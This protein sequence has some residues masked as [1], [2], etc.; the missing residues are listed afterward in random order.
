MGY[1][2]TTNSVTRVHEGSR[3]SATEAGKPH[4]RMG[5][6]A[7]LR[8]WLLAVL[9]V[10]A[11]L[12]LFHLGWP[13]LGV[14]E[15]RFGISALNILSD[16]HQL[17]IV[18]EDPLGGVGT[19]PYLYPL[20]L[21][22]SIALLG[23]TEFAVRLVNVLVLALGGLFVYW[24][25]RSATRKDGLALLTF[26]SFLLNP[27]TITYARSA[28][29][30]PLVV[31]A[32]CLALL[33]AEKWRLTFSLRWAVVCGSALGFGYMAK[34]WLVAP[35]GGAAFIV[36]LGPLFRHKEVKTVLASLAALLFSFL[37]AA[38]THLLLVA[39]LAPD[40]IRNWL[41]L[42]FLFSL[43]TRVAGGGYDPAMWFRPWWFYGGVLFKSTFFALPLF[44]TGLEVLFRQRRRT[45]I[46]VVLVLLSPVILFSAVAVKQASYIY[47][48]FTAVAFLLAIGCAAV[49]N[50]EDRHQSLVWGLPLS[51]LIAFFFFTKQLFDAKELLAI[52]TVYLGY[53]F[54]V[55][56]RGRRKRT[57]ITLAF[58]TATCVSLFSD[59]LVV[60]QMLQSRTH[61]R[62]IAAFLARDLQG[63]NP[64]DLAFIA[65][66]FPAME[67]YTFRSGEYWGTFYRHK[68]LTSFLADLQSGKRK[69]YI[70]DR[71]GKLYG[72]RLLPGIF[73]AVSTHARDITSE[74]ENTEREKLEVQVFENVYPGAVAFR[75]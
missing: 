2:L 59:A 4:T 30:E 55:F 57:A 52:E 3:R 72:S 8:L 42:Y 22:A 24:T 53:F 16:P 51:G 32:G 70:V 29:P 28:M 14:D 50:D 38:S 27:W 12:A 47:P 31:C 17:A 46:G 13:D 34:L 66:E 23:R 62:E 9:T 39:L 35:F 11:L 54:V 68:S 44:F 43:K 37:L 74:V 41:N 61:Y 75:Q 40:L 6:R 45:A 58:V 56:T 67:F 73:E 48:A 21:A 63:M 25:I 18:S 20:T 64:R 49:W 19:K 36:F 1:E 60:R 7:R 65:P 69:F 10:Y 15:G 33:A 71:S 26:S 5:R